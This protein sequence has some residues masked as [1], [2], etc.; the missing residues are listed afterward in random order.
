MKSACRGRGGVQKKEKKK[1][2]ESI[3]VCCLVLI[4]EVTGANPRGF[5]RFELRHAL[6][7]TIVC[8]P[9]FPVDAYSNESFV[10]AAVKKHTLS[11][12][13]SAQRSLFVSIKRLSFRGIFRPIFRF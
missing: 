8:G 6:S 13:R 4:I 3:T 7:L 1:E 2:E 9:S 11:A 12:S 5:I 10:S